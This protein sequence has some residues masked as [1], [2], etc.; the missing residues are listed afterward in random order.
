MCRH[1][2]YL[3]ER[4]TLKSVLY[5][6]PHSLIDQ[7]WAPRLQ[8]H[9]T[10]NVDGFGVGWYA[11]GDRIPARYRRAGP[12][13]A[14][15]DLRDLAR[16]TRTRAMLCAVRS[17]SVGTDAGAAAAAPFTDGSWL[18]SLNGALVGWSAAAGGSTTPRRR[19]T[20]ALA[21]AGSALGSSGSAALTVPGTES[22]AAAAVRT[23]LGLQARCDTALL[24]AMVLGRLR[25]GERPASA[26]VGTIARIRAAGG[27]GRFN[28]LLTDGQMIAATA[29]GDSL[30]YSR[31]RTH[32]IVASEPFDDEPDWQ[33]VPDGSVVEATTAG[34]A[35]RPLA[36]TAPAAKAPQHN[37]DRA[38]R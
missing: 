21:G 13:W 29:A 17:A 25:A 9:G 5:D 36:D 6:P 35:V 30:C 12:I 26:L 1:F 11:D 31:R 3:G 37:G 32:V 34:V 4:V 18:F 14:D 7:A 2:A 24:W 28:L 23:L 27:I 8:K 15:D 20:A 16:V 38:V 19:T 10:M 33:E 22:A